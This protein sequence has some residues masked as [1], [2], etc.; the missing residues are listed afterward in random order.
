[1]EKNSEASEIEREADIVLQQ[2]IGLFCSEPVKAVIKELESRTHDSFVIKLDVFYY[3]YIM[4]KRA[5][6]AR[7]GK[8]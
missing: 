6:R 4:G 7:R 8:A 5:E 2:G 3:G 1:M